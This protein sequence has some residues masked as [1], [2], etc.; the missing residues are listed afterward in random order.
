MMF[1]APE[2]LAEQIASHLS[3]LIIT[4]QLKPRERIQ[5]LKVAGELDVSRGSVRE[6]LLILERRHVI[7]IYPR[8]GA[9]VSDLSVQ[10]VQALY[11]MVAG[12]VTMLAVRFAR[13]W[14]PADFA[15]VTRQVA[16]VL[17]RMDDKEASVEVVVDAGLDLLPLC[18][19]VVNNPYLEE[20]L[21]NFRP[22]ISR[23]Y[24]LAMKSQKAAVAESRQFFE[25]MIEVV[26]ERQVDLIPDLVE[27]FAETQKRLAIAALQARSAA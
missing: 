17:K 9:V 8:K 15:A 12:L 23:T 18:Y 14:Q 20:T 22:A 5:E 25:K 26:R 13:H 10:H 11:D 4:G 24:F 2:S 16:N 27:H 19:P 3:R 6:A 1:Q 7:E 21:E